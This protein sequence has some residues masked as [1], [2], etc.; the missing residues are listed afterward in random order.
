MA[1]YM[2]THSKSLKGENILHCMNISFNSKIYESVILY[3]MP[4]NSRLE[5]KKIQ[6]EKVC[7]QK[8][9]NY[10]LKSKKLRFNHTFFGMGD[11]LHC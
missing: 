11:C 8:H 9:T 5:C 2:T 3:P 7:N 1:C 10:L 6:F 4:I